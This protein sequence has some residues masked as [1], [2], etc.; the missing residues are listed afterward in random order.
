TV[1]PP[2]PAS[3]FTQPSAGLLPPVPPPSAIGSTSAATQGGQ[4]QGRPAD[5]AAQPQPGAATAP[6][7]I[8]PVTANDGP[9]RTRSTPTAVTPPIPVPAPSS[10]PPSRPTVSTVP[11]VDSY[12]EETYRLKAGDTF[13]KISIAHYN[14]DKYAKALERWN[15]NHPQAMEKLRTDP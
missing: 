10:A 14:T 5:A 2:P 15:V 8:V 4:P 9:R 13:A 3:S 7:P 12:D 6:Q 1:S 11:Q